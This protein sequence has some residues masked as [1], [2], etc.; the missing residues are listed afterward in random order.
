MWH[1]LLGFLQHLE[2]APINVFIIR[3]PCKCHNY[4]PCCKD[5]KGQIQTK[6]LPSYQG[7]SPSVVL[8]GVGESVGAG[9]K[10]G[11]CG[12]WDERQVVQ[13][14]DSLEGVGNDGEVE[15]RRGQE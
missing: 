3:N 15:G 9:V 14:Q 7:E 1:N 4:I 8:L 11:G 6:P 10:G 12:G 13:C 5:T 2:I